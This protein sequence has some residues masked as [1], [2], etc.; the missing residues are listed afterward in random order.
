MEESFREVV[1][2]SSTMARMGLEVRNDLADAGNGFHSESVRGV[3]SS[4]STTTEVGDAMMVREVNNRTNCERWREFAD[5]ERRSDTFWYDKCVTHDTRPLAFVIRVIAFLTSTINAGIVRASSMIVRTL[6]LRAR[7][8]RPSYQRPLSSL[9]PALSKVLVANR[10]EIACRVLR[11]CREWG[12]PSVALYSVADGHNCTHATMADESYQVGSGPTPS[13]SYLQA[14]QVLEIAQA[15]GVDA[16]HPG[17]GFLSENEGFAR[18]TIDAGIKWIG[19]PP[20]SMASMA[21]KSQAKAIM[22]QAGV[23]TTPG[24]Y[25]D[26]DQEPEFLLA[27]AK[28]I[29]FPVLIKAVLGGGGK[30]MRLVWNEKDFVDSLRACQ[31]EALASFGDATVLL[32]KYLVDPRHVELQILADSHGNVVSL[33]ERD[34]SL[35]RR[36]QK[37]I[38]EAPASDLSPELRA[39]LG[40]KARKA[41]EAVRYVNAGTVEFLLEGSNFYFCEMNT[42]LQVEHPITELVTGVDLVEWQ[43]RV[44]AGEELGFRQEDIAEIGHAFEARIYAEQPSK[45]FLPATGHVWHHRPPAPIHTG[46]NDQGIRVDSFLQT[47]QDISVYYD[48]MIAKL[49][50]HDE[51]RD[52]ALKKLAKALKDYQ[53]AGVPTNMDFLIQCSQHPVFGQQG[54]INTGFLEKYGDEIRLKEPELPIEAKAVGALVVSH[55]LE[56]R[57]GPSLHDTNLASPWSAHSGSWRMGGEASRARR[58]ISMVDSEEQM[59][60]ISNRD[61]S[62]EVEV[63]GSV[64]HIH[65]SIGDS[66]TMEVVLNGS[67]RIHATTV[68]RE[69]DGVLQ[70][71]IWPNNDPAAYLWEM[72]FEH[73]LNAT[74][75]DDSVQ[76]TGDDVVKAPMPGKISRLQAAVGDTVTQGQVILVMEAM[77]MEHAITAPRDGILGE[78]RYKPGDVVDDGAILLIMEDEAEAA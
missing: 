7:T 34:C 75:T 29:G 32:E 5:V 6:L 61:G 52:K 73:P 12:I 68:L 53:I 64:L 70:I 16:I 3:G 33:L 35:Q 50:V 74:G 36:H 9:P 47:G 40:L 38:E 67:K 43:L 48:P 78:I 30:G 77:K 21:S 76:G 46:A 72:N 55:Y 15:T 57:I 59:V 4:P 41:A 69:I 31:G 42:R 66:G 22:E 19:P 27:K 65:G 24:Y 62:F 28:E 17:Y 11:T 54:A 20:E 71:R 51:N 26:G 56:G 8:P 63:D 49:I 45:G 1:R 13:E 14:Q 18:A 10:G 25:S 2:I 44:A 39:D 60:C 23:P 37:I 58:T